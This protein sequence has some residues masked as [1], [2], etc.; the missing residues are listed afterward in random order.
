MSMSPEDR[1]RF[2]RWARLTSSQL[3]DV[4]GLPDHEI[5]SLIE[6][7]VFPAAQCRPDIAPSWRARKVA[8]WAWGLQNS[9]RL[10]DQVE[11][12]LGRRDDNWPKY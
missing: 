3:A 11:F 5:R 1:D 10:A 4:V 8:A 7:G 9:A 2:D 6:F 12:V